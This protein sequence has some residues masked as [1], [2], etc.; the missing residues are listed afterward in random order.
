MS[1][2]KKYGIL[3]WE[4]HGV[5]LLWKWALEK[6]PLVSCGVV[7]GRPSEILWKVVL[8]DGCGPRWAEVGPWK[9]FVLMFCLCIPTWL[10]S[11]GYRCR[12]VFILSSSWMKS[13]HKQTQ[14]HAMLKLFSN[15]STSQFQNRCQQNWV[16][17][18]INIHVFVCFFMNAH[19]L[20]LD[21]TL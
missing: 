13:L 12:C 1:K 7:E 14:N 3:P 15:T 6:L 8:L 5:Y 2:D 16:H 9:W 18:L 4:R 17:A 21:Q 19:L 10:C 20:P 11:G